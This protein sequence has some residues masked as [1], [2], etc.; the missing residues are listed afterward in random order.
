MTT[1]VIA[2]L[3]AANPVPAPAGASARARRPARRRVLVLVV[4]A[5]VAVPAAAFADRLGGVLGLSNQGSPVATDSLSLMRATKLAEAVNELGVPTTMQLLGTRGG[6][7]FYVARRA[8]GDYCFAIESDAGKGVGCDFTGAFPSPSRPVMFF[9]PFRRFAGFAADGVA[10]V[11]GLDA[12][13]RI[14]GSAPVVDN[15]FAAG[16]QTQAI[17]SLEALD[18]QGGPVWTQRLPGR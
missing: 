17:V 5:A 9:P 15:I 14:V 16:A 3:A 8:D 4:V 11:A 1:E 7:S 13:G 2:R 10:S 12:D 6:I 18:A